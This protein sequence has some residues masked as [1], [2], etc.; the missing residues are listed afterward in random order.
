[1]KYK[2]VIVL[3]NVAL[4]KSI[5][6]PLKPSKIILKVPHYLEKATAVSL[7]IQHLRR[8]EVHIHCISCLGISTNFDHI[9]RREILG[10]V[11]Q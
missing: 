2:N 4:R 9:F 8:V 1:M 3:K 6:L 10:F 7:C 11:M 5:K